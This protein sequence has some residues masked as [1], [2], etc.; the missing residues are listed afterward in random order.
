MVLKISVDEIN[1]SLKF[2]AFI[3]FGVLFAI[4]LVQI[5]LAKTI[6]WQTT[7]VISGLIFVFLLTMVLIKVLRP[8]VRAIRQKRQ[9]RKQLKRK[10][11]FAVIK[12]W[13][14]IRLY[15]KIMLLIWV[16]IL[17]VALDFTAY[18]FGLMGRQEKTYIL[19][20]FGFMAITAS[21]AFIIFY[22]SR[23][24]RKK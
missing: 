6:F 4:S 13:F 11:T 10:S 2:S 22:L 5:I 8:L 14:K 23:L 12:E 20:N 17:L 7:G 1:K 24:F 3:A 19:A 15:F 21:A 16:I 18:N 9:R